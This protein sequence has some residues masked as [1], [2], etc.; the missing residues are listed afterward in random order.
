MCGHM[1]YKNVRPD[2]IS[3]I[4]DVSATALELKQTLVPAEFLKKVHG[5]GSKSSCSG[6]VPKK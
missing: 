2:P 1:S 5:S 6:K 3:D 4:L